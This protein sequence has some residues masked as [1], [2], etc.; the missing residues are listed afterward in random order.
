MF[1][2]GTAANRDANTQVASSCLAIVS[3]IMSICPPHVHARWS[4][5][6]TFTYVQLQPPTAAAAAGKGQRLQLQVSS[7]FRAHIAKSM[8]NGMTDSTRQTE[9]EKGAD[10]TFN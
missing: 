6:D 4:T 5:H 8:S 2:M 1:G 9:A 7:R 3:I 10:I